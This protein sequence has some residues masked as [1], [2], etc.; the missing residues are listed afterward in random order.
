MTREIL[1]TKIEARKERDK[2][3]TIYHIM[4]MILGMPYLTICPYRERERERL[5][6][7]LFKKKTHTHTHTNFTLVFKCRK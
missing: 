4:I 7:N 5:M 3:S 2:D 6:V 1:S